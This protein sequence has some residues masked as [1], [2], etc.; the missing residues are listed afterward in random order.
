M[1]TVMADANARIGLG[2]TAP[3]R[4]WRAT[5]TAA[6]VAAGANVVVYGLA[7]LAGVSFLMTMMPGTEPIVLPVGMVVTMSVLGAA[8]GAI[9]FAAL[10]RFG[11]RGVSAF[12]ALGI[13][14][15]LLSFGGPLSLEATDAAT[16]AALM[17][18][19]V[20]AGGSIITLLSGGGRRPV[21]AAH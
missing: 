14:F 18:M 11:A 10:S 12:R 4:G 8:L 16:K 2:A 5:L 6:A 1:A 19:H 3:G 7:R 15:L 13:V 21:P 17:L 20:V 9:A